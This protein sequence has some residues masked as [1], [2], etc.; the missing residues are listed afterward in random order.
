MKICA[1]ICEFNPFHFGHERLLREARARSGCDFLVCVM[2]GFFT[3]RGVMACSDRRERAAFALEAGADMVT[4]LPVNFSVSP[5]EIFAAGAVKEVACLPGELTLAFG[6]GTENKEEITRGARIM[7]EEPD[8]FKEVLSSS[9]SAGESYIRALQRAFEACG[10]EKDFLTVPNDILALEYEKAIEERD[11][12][13]DILPIKRFEGGNIMSASAIREDPLSEK[14]RA[15][16]P[17]YAL[18]GL[19]DNSAAERKYEQ[20]LMSSLFKADKES[21]RR[22]FGCGEGL[23]NRLKKLENL[24]YDKF[25]GEANSRRYTTARIKRI[26]LSAALG[27]YEDETKAL[28]CEP[29][30]PTV[31]A[32]TKDAADALMPEMAKTETS[33]KALELDRSEDAARLWEFL[34]EKKA[35]RGVF[36]KD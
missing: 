35:P 30:R 12:K 15:A 22:C 6:C 21:L 26:L 28:L 4:E 2:S 7:L 1:V 23:E 8:D 25:I 33:K 5:A 3:Q 32:A 27:L 13:I 17:A 24:P 11:L 14:S 9:L 19:R 34:N 31:I 10:G 18:S 36:A 29:L 20:H 16:V